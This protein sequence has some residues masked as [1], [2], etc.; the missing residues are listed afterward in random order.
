MAQL[1]IKSE[2]AYA[3]AADLATL[4][5]ESLTTAVTAALRERLER[6]RRLRERAAKLQRLAA[7]AGEIRAHMRAPAGS[8]HR[9]LYDEAG[10]P[11]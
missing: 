1:N 10:L 5:G 3:L 9:W 6:E 2:E 8:D 7:I 11:A 4:T